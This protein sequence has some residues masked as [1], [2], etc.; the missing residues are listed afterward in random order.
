MRNLFDVIVIGGGA[1]GMTSA[2]RLAQ[3]GR[4]V[5]LLE[6]GQLGGEASSAAAG[7]LGAQLEVSE[8][9]AFY[10]LCLESRALYAQFVDEL[11]S[12]TGIDAQLSH[13][14]ILQMAF[15]ATHV[16]ALKSRMRWQIDHGARAEWLDAD[17]VKRQE[18]HLAKALGALLLPDDSNVNTPLLMRALAAAVKQICQVC[19]G[20]H[21]TDIEHQKTGDGYVVKTA[22]GSYWGESV[23]VAAG[24]WSQRLLEPFST[25]CAIRPVKGQLAAIRPRQGLAIRHTIYS[26]PVYLVPK[27]DGTIVVGATEER[28]AGYNRDVTIDALTTLFTAVARMA[29]GLRDAIFERTWMGLRPGSPNG[30]PW[31]GEVAGAPGLHVAVGHFRNGILL[32]PVT[33]KMVVQSVSR[34]PWPARWQPFHVAFQDQFQ[35]R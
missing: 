34:E 20:S 7:M 13:N 1:I 17:E 5:L 30:Q 22:T 16:T 11:F 14:G 19:E 27:R 10:Q 25:P 31:I 35:P 26:A 29:P 8:P 6:Q 18:P 4:R 28:E 2:W 33:A 12:L 15:D 21:V 23:V 24:A 32:A 3:T 9:G